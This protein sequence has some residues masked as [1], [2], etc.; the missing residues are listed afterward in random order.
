HPGGLQWSRSCG[1]SMFRSCRV[2]TWWTPSTRSGV[3]EMTYYRWRPSPGL[4]AAARAPR[5][6]MPAPPRRAG[7]TRAA[8][9]FDQLVGSCKESVRYGEA[10]RVGRLEIDDQ[11]ELNRGLHGKIARLFAFQDAIR[12]SCRAP[13]II[14]P[15]LSVGQ[16]PTKFSEK[17]LSINGRETI[18]SRQRCDLR[19]VSD[20]ERVQNHEKA[21]IRFA[22]LCG[23]DGLKFGCIVDRCLYHLHSERRSSSFER[24][25]PKFEE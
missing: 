6:A 7:L 17:T 2:R 1:R 21:A 18:A 3:S 22:C 5:A 25:E 24:L 8:S 10:E 20:R 4:S 11:L 13:K 16:Q 15:V 23:H 14:G 9:S 19:A 12:I